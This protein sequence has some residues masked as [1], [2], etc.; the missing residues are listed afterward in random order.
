MTQSILIVESQAKTL[1]RVQSSLKLLGKLS[2]NLL[3]SL[4]TCGSTYSYAIQQSHMWQINNEKRRM[5]EYKN[6]SARKILYQPQSWKMGLRK[7][8]KLGGTLSRMLETMEYRLILQIYNQSCLTLNG[9]KHT[10]FELLN[11]RIAGSCSYHH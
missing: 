6:L 10:R 7:Y 8:L 2:R 5:A 1:T 11:L 9:I 3:D 4:T